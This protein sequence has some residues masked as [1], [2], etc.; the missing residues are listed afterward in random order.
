[1]P[2]ETPRDPVSRSWLKIQTIDEGGVTRM[3]G[4]IV[5]WNGERSRRQATPIRHSGR[6]AADPKTVSSR[7]GERPSVMSVGGANMVVFA[8][9]VAP[10]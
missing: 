8:M 7:R 6:I 2:P 4:L 9:M 10:R 5:R 3:M 1:M